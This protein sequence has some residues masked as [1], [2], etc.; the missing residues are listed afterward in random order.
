MY[1]FDYTRPTSIAEAVSAIGTSTEARFLAGGQTLVPTLKQRLARPG[2]LV[3]LAGL[4]DLRGVEQSGNAIGI[5]AMTTHAEVAASDV[6]LKAIPA[7]AKLAAGIGDP[8]VRHRGT[9]GGSIANNDPAS[10][11]PAGVLGLGATLVTDRRQIKADDFF[12]G[13]FTTALQ[14]GEMITGIG[15]PIPEKAAYVKMEQRASRYALVGV[16]VAKTSA[17]VRVAVTGAGDSGVFRV[18]AFEAAL[19]ARFAPDAIAGTSVSPAGL[20][21]DIHAS[22]E[23]RASLISVLTERAVASLV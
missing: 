10:D 23:Y 12:K 18:A 13:L 5:G 3:D 20:M 14:P 8:M 21:S 16:F 17:G 4:K 22:A 7:L 1:S 2:K 9:I 15:F 19:T 6:V 11:Y